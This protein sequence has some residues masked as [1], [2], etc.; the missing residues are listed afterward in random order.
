MPSKENLTLSFPHSLKPDLQALAAE[1]GYPNNLSGLIQAIARGELV[2]QR[3][4]T[5]TRVNRIEGELDGVWV[6]IEELRQIA[7]GLPP[8]GPTDL[9]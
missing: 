7:A 2:L 8:A 5:T 9:P 6:A 1:H 4:S 3:P